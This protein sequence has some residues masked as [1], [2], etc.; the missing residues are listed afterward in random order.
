M[1]CV[2]FWSVL[3]VMQPVHIDLCE[4]PDTAPEPIHLGFRAGV[5]HLT[6]HLMGLGNIAIN[7]VAINIRFNCADVKTASGRLAEMVLTRFSCGPK[8]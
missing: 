4:A 3:P 6:R 7:R 5:N 2:S 1:P 8:G